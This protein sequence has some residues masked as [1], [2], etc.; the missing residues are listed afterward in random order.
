MKTGVPLA[1]RKFD[2]G[3][4]CTNPAS[5]L[6][7]SAERTMCFA[8]TATPGVYDTD[9]DSYAD[10]IYAPDLGGNVWKWVIKAPLQLSDATTATQPATDWP[11]R[12]FF[13]AE[14]YARRSNI[15]YRASTPAGGHAQ[16]RQDLAAFGSASATTCS[17]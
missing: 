12:K 9:G 8:M 5:V 6:N 3:G 14:P 1:V 15:Y 2:T 11:F 10:V 7:T 13:S 16:E 17:T 4:D